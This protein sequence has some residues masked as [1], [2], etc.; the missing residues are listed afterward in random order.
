[1]NP[2]IKIGLYLGLIIAAAVFG[3]LFYSSYKS[4]NKE[5]APINIPGSI[6]NELTNTVNNSTNSVASTNSAAAVTNAQGA[7]PNIVAEAPSISAPQIAR[8]AAK[9]RSTMVGYFA[10][11]LLM[12]LFLGLLLARDVSEYFGSRSVEFMFNDDGVGI[13]DPDYEEAEQEWANG[14]HLEAIRLMRDYLI[15]NPR[16]QGV[17][18][19][20]AEIYEKDLKNN[21][22]A[23]LEYEEILKHKLPPQRWGWAA[24]HLCNLYSKL[25]K[26]DQAVALLHRV[27]NEYGETPAAE[28][29]RK[30]LAMFETVGEE[31]LDGE[32]PDSIQGSLPP[33][34]TEEKSASNLPPGFR[35]KS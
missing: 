11:F 26:T 31:A 20:I 21:L 14:H 3:G 2:K 35:P 23:A 7:A 22:A 24:I 27:V 5:A 6:S 9:G 16:E 8:P 1:M 15:R 30:R 18:L 28:K 17:A 12:A 34:A 25:H 29:A 13:K 10:A 4:A 32:L 33:K 19:R